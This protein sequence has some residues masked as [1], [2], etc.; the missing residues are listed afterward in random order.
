MVYLENNGDGDFAS[1]FGS[2]AAERLDQE[3]RRQTEML[4]RLLS[5]FEARGAAAAPR[6][7]PR[8]EHLRITARGDI[9]DDE[10]PPRGGRRAFHNKVHTMDDLPR[11]SEYEQ[12]FGK[13]P[14][15][16]EA[17]M[18]VQSGMRLSDGKPTHHVS[19]PGIEEFVLAWSGSAPEALLL[20]LAV[21]ILVVL[22]AG[23]IAHLVR[24]LRALSAL[25]RGAPYG[26]PYGA[27][28]PAYAMV[29]PAGAHYYHHQP[30][31]PVGQYYHNTA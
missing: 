4:L 2:V 26:T 25:R 6:G 12:L 3:E 17:Q 14:P 1:V 15:P 27:P 13:P 23:R 7:A 18:R 9:V 24:S 10:P 20:A 21:L 19:F 28:P 29:H 31:E 11:E 30:V 22:I 5:E 16:P 8:V